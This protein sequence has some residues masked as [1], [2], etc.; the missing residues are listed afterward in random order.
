MNEE[1]K[2]K[3][4][5]H[6]EEVNP[7]NEEKEYLIYDKAQ[8]EE[9]SSQ[10][11]QRP[12]KCSWNWGAFIFG[13]IYGIFNKSWICLITLI[14]PVAQ[15]FIG[16]PFPWWISYVLLVICGI[17]GE[18]FSYDNYLHSKNMFDVKAWKKR[19][20][21]WDIVGFAFAVLWLVGLAFLAGLL[22]NPCFFVFPFLI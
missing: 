9:G 20:R 4:I 14:P 22:L 17:L 11:T 2:T 5:L 12:V 10:N 15:W 1:E 6:E 13:W 19:Q 16:K 8:M 7:T 3:D 21:R 18:Q